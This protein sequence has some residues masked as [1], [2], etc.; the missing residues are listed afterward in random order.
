MAVSEMEITTQ[1]FSY[2]DFFGTLLS[3]SKCIYFSIRWCCPFGADI[4]NCCKCLGR[5]PRVIDYRPFRAL[6]GVAPKGQHAIAQ[7]QRLGLW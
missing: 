1:K 6:Q 4:A 3:D 7:R 2:R 5:C